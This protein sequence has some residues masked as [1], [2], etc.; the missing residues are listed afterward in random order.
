MGE[1]LFLRA[2]KRRAG[3]KQ[4][5]R[6]ERSIVQREDCTLSKDSYVLRWVVWKV[7]REAGRI[8]SRNENKLPGWA[9]SERARAAGQKCDL[10]NGV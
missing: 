3:R 10:T 8:V 7:G 2:N 6:G 4:R 9:A 5:R 1:A